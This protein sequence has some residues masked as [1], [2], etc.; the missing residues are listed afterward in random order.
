MNIRILV[1]ILHDFIFF[2][3]SFF[4]SLWIRLDLNSALILCKELW[5]F[6]IIFSFTNIFLLK[7]MGLYHGI[8]RYASIHEIVSIF[9]SITISTL[10]IIFSFFIIFRLESIPR[11]FPVLLFIV[12]FWYEWKISSGDQRRRSKEN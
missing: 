3:V 4:I 6:L 5:W 10:I 11:S 1:T 7:Y 12:S 8:W 9:K 2:G